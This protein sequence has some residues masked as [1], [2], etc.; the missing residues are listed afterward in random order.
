MSQ[1]IYP[2]KLEPILKEKV[3]GGRRLA[4]LGKNLPE[5]AL[6][7]ESWELADLPCTSPS[8][9]G[10]DAARS[11]IVNGSLAGQSLNHALKAWQ[12]AMMGKVKPT[13]QGNFPLLVKFLDARENLSVQVHPSPEYASTH[14]EA[15]LKTESWLVLDAEPFSVIYKGFKPGVTREQL[16][17]AL[18]DVGTSAGGR[19]VGG[20]GGGVVE[21]LQSVPA[22]VGQ[23]HDLPSSTIHALGAG[24]LVAEIQTPSDTTFRVYDWANEYQRP[25]R[26][27]H[28]EQALACVDYGSA[29]QAVTAN[30][31]GELVQTPFYSIFHHQITKTTDLP[32]SGQCPTVIMVLSGQGRVVSAQCDPV[33][34]HLGET[35]LVPA[36][37]VGTTSLETQGAMQL[38]IAEAGQPD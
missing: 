37:L 1:Q 30:E 15:H 25:A 18:L 12:A 36:A 2:L 3:W 7:G 11:I 21:L 38:L 14:P 26:Q 4:K 34:V 31:Q 22:I 35:V 6:I 13:A 5:N 16:E 27:L 24:T 33:K 19:R 23:C 10:G 8:G 28:V 17:Q 20:G 32:G 9:G 29:P